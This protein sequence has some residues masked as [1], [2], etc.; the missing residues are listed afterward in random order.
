MVLAARTAPG[1]RMCAPCWVASWQRG[2]L[3]DSSKAGQATGPCQS[4]HL[5][6]KEVR[7]GTIK[8]NPYNLTFLFKSFISNV[9]PDDFFS[10]ELLELDCEVHQLVVDL[11]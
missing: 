3:Q 8:I 1:V 7:D 2:G 6:I 11:Q 4:L 9:F 5:L 10:A